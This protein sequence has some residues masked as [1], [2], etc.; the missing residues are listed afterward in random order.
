MRY[1][2]RQ[3][4][5]RCSTGA[6]ME[7]MTRVA[8]STARPWW[9]AVVLLVVVAMVSAVFAVAEPGRGSRGRPERVRR[10]RR[11]PGWT[12][13]GRVLGR[14]PVQQYYV[15]ILRNEGLNAFDAVDIATVTP[16]TLAAHDVVVLGEVPIN[17]S[18]AA[19]LAAWVADGGNLIAMRPDPD[20]AALVGVTDTGTDLSDEYLQIDTA[21][22][23]PGAGLVG[24]TIQF[25]GTADRY[26]LD[27]GTDALATLWSTASTATTNPAV[28]LRSV[29][30][31]GGE[32]AAFAFD[33]ARSV[34][35]TR[36]GNPA[37]AGQERDGQQ[38]PI[39]RSDDLFFP[40][41]IDFDK[42]QIPQADEQQRLLANLIEHVEPR[43]HAAAPLLV[44]PARRAGRRRD[45]R[46]RPRERQRHRG[47][48]RLGQS[49][50]SAR[51]RRRRLAVRARHVVRVPEHPARRRGRRGLRSAG[52]RGG[53]PR[54]HE[55]RR[56]DVRPPWRAS[57]TT[58]CWRSRRR[59][60]ALP[61]RR[62]TAPTASPGATGRHI[63][64]SSSPRASASTRTTTTGRRRG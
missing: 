30:S 44:L 39:L 19:M 1:A 18:Q 54:R 60:P 24:Q 22:G 49:R 52:L 16:A 42:V 33:L 17:A 56:L 32:V 64:R 29:G 7:P 4:P 11:R 43:R 14:A 57:S 50:Q 47:P 46:R 21:A 63:R 26:D 36:Q 20:L 25:H 23:T 3:P 15:E 2:M 51:L 31:N 37:W 10:R 58:S 40:D 62:P 12:D 28:T 13:P 55:L 41:W 5:A 34:V 8:P 45:D 6:E 61:R 9:R 48:V 35:Y 53:P 59:T 27:A 38:P